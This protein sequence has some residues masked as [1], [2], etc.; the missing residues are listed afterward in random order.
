MMTLSISVSW[1]AKHLA[2]ATCSLSIGTS[3]PLPCF[4]KS[5]MSSPPT[6]KD[7]L[8]DKATILLFSN[9]SIV[10]LKPTKPTKAL[11]TI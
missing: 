2:I 9:A 11:T 7:S 5:L 3:L 8:F 1:T 4:N 6:T 10:G